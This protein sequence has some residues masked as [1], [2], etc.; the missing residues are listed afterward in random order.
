MVTILE[1]LVNDELFMVR[2]FFYN[3]DQSAL[4]D[5]K[6]I[7]LHPIGIPRKE[8][9]EKK[10]VCSINNDVFV[11]NDTDIAWK[12]TAINRSKVDDID[13]NADMLSNGN[14]Q[15]VLKI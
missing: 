12:S 14:S 8:L 4:K 7:T 6:C 2:L 10:L 11:I 15:L 9:E 1:Q 13:I 3:K 5:M